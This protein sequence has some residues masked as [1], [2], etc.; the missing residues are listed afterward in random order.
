MTVSRALLWALLFLAYAATTLLV[1]LAMLGAGLL[2]RWNG[3]PSPGADVLAVGLISAAMAG[4]GV[5]IAVSE[6]PKWL[7]LL[8]RGR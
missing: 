2:L 5:V 1:A 3:V 7:V 6:P 8:L 4:G